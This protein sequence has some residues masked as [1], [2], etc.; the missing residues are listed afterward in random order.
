MV[1]CAVRWFLIVFA[2]CAAPKDP[3]DAFVVNTIAEDNYEFSLRDPTLVA[4]KLTKMQRDPFDWLRGTA[5]VYWHDVTDP[6]A[7]RMPTAFG[8]PAS[9]RVLLVA[10]PHPEN[11]G[12]FR[13]PDGTMFMDWNDFDSSGYGP[14]EGDVRRLA[15]GLMIATRD[16]DAAVDTLALDPAFDDEIAHRV[17]TGYVA[18]IGELAAG[19]P[20][21]PVTTG[22][23]KYFDKL[24]AKAIENG[25]ANK[26][27]NDDTAVDGDGTRYFV[28]GDQDPVADDGVIESRLSAPTDIERDRVT[29]AM[30]SWLAQHA[31]LGN[32][33]DIA[34]RYGSGVSS[35]AA[36]RYYVLLASDRIVEVKEERDGIVIHG[37][38]ELEAAE[39]TTPAQRVV[40]AQRRLQLRRDGDTLL[41]AADLSPLAFRVHD[42]TAY[43]RGVNS[44][45]LGALAVDPSK[46]SQVPDLAELFGRLLARAHGA[47][48]TADGVPGWTVI[49]PVLGDGFG[50]ELSTLA[51]ADAAQTVADWQS[52]RT[53]DLAAVAIPARSE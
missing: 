46:R 36:L 8:D 20:A 10:D 30:T 39:W 5:P 51:Q 12:S 19:M 44:T 52:L 1:S 14:F 35:Y 37:V 25:D 33:V 16:P 41:G 53:Q 50:D 4:M 48:L 9:S 17:A 34:R 11:L 22:A 2:A 47:A 38:P 24:I 6:G 18:Q 15:A 45:D 26:E 49:M 3:R 40:D 29:R 31:D 7:P 43:Q 28:L 21:L 13:A 32:I 23:A 27:V 42:E